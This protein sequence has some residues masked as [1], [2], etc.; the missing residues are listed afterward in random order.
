MAEPRLRALILGATCRQVG[1]TVDLLW[2]VMLA[3]RGGWVGHDGEGTQA[4]QK[5]HPRGSREVEGPCV[6]GCYQV[7]E[8][9][10]S[11][12][13]AEDTSGRPLPA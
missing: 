5:W 2:P 9:D 7:G 12:P 11:I 1:V 13:G 10:L 4:E 3:A 8:G 6:P